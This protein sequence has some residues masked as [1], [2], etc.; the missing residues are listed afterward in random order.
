ML[1]EK[2]GKYHFWLTFV[3][4]HTTFLVQHWLGTKPGSTVS[5]LMIIRFG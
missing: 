3:G 5:P 4:F 2:L 1:D